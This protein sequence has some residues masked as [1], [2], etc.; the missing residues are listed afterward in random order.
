[1]KIKK[2]TAAK[3]EDYDEEQ[4]EMKKFLGADFMQSFLS[5]EMNSTAAAAGATQQ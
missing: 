4:L 3:K 5:P 1:M 2:T